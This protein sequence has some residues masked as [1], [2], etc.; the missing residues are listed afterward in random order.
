MY[1]LVSC[2]RA[3]STG[4]AGASRPYHIVGSVCSCYNPY[5]LTYLL[6]RV[7]V[8]HWY[9]CTTR[10]LSWNRLK[11]QTFASGTWFPWLRLASELASGY[12][13]KVFYWFSPSCGFD[14]QRDRVILLISSFL[15]VPVS[16]NECVR[17][18]VLPFALFYFTQ[19]EQCGGSCSRWTTVVSFIAVRGDQLNFFQW[20]R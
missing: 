12:V 10:N 9:T 5:L 11:V 14:F 13:T 4:E 19:R 20:S 1:P 17:A 18:S 8:Y 6:T 2:C 15:W 16:G 7:H 3:I